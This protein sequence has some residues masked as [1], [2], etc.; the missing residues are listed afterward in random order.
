MPIVLVMSGDEKQSGGIGGFGGG[1]RASVWNFHN[2]PER[3]VAPQLELL[4]CGGDREGSNLI[5]ATAGFEYSERETPL[6]IGLNNRKK[7]G[8]FNK[9]D[10][11]LNGIF[12]AGP[13][14]VKNGEML[15][16]GRGAAGLGVV[17]FL[18]DSPLFWDLNV[19]PTLFYRGEAVGKFWNKF[20][21][22][23]T[24]IFGATFLFED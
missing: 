22:A 1:L 13:V 16:G 24:I 11:Y 4:Y 17:M 21:I 10:V 20:E 14:Y 19:G 3:V 18:G 8:T 12:S 9:L 2:A 23:P 5:C 15:T 7:L 6:W